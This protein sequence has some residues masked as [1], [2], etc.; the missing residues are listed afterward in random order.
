MDVAYVAQF[1]C[2]DE[3]EPTGRSCNRDTRSLLQWF[4]CKQNKLRWRNLNLERQI[5]GCAKNDD[6]KL[7][8][9]KKQNSLS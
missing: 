4:T 5:T 8:Y 3:L 6:A 7:S 2:F 1:Q 9:K